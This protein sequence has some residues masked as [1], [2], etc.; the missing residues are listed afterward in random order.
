M[1]AAMAQQMAQLTAEQRRAVLDG[2][3]PEELAVLEYKWEFWARPDQLP[4]AGEWRTWL[5]LGGRGSGKTRSSAEWVRAEM[6]SGRR[7]NM[8]LIGPT[9]DDVRNTMIEG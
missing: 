4:P 1:T 3:S 5:L 2:L 7:R 6:E 8:G 9:A